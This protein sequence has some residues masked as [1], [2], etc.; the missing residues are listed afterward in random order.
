[1]RTLFSE[2]KIRQEGSPFC[3]Y[4][5]NVHSHI[6]NTFAHIHLFF[7]FFFF[8]GRTY[9]FWLTFFLER[10]YSRLNWLLTIKKLAFYNTAFS[11]SSNSL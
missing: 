5:F 9:A 10:K 2:L 3:K 4:H 7:K 11:S 8:P 6:T 1:M